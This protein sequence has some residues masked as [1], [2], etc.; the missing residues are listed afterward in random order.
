MVIKTGEI[1][2]AGN[3]TR[4]KSEMRAKLYS[5]NLTEGSHFGKGGIDESTTLKLR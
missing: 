1:R 3:V 4:T 5:E 2:W